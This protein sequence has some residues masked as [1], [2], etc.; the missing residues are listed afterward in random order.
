MS[1]LVMHFVVDGFIAFGPKKKR[2]EKNIWYVNYK[3]IYI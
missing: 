1:T 2:K 3:D